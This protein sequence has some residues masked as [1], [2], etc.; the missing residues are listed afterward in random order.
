M[1]SILYSND[2]PATKRNN[3]F[4]LFKLCTMTFRYY[5]PFLI[6]FGLIYAIGSSKK[7]KQTQTSK[8]VLI[9]VGTFLYYVFLVLCNM[10]THWATEEYKIDFFGGIMI[11]HNIYE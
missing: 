11:F 7:V 10:F 9:I 3:I 5:A 8:I 6:M 4:G 1:L 2:L